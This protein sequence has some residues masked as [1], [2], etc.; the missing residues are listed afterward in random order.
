MPAPVFTTRGQRRLSPQGGGGPG[1]G[2]DAQRSWGT[3]YGCGRWSW[4]RS[5]PWRYPPGSGR[6]SSHGG[7]TSSLVWAAAGVPVVGRRASSFVSWAAWELSRR[8]GTCGKLGSSAPVPPAA[9]V[10]CRWLAVTPVQSFSSPRSPARGLAPRSGLRLGTPLPLRLLGIVVSSGFTRFH[11]RASNPQSPRQ[12]FPRFGEVGVGTRGLMVDSRSAPDW[13]RCLW[14]CI[15]L[16][17]D[18]LT[19][20]RGEK[21]YLGCVALECQTKEQTCEALVGSRPVYSSGYLVV[22]RIIEVCWRIHH[23][24]KLIPLYCCNGYRVQEELSKS[25]KIRPNQY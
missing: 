25:R 17:E 20:C 11:L 14:L 1:R 6:R 9:P 10:A 3:R 19:V 22:S 23:S 15:S 12:R 13:R 8:F 21:I 4:R 16:W 24:T 2:R 5:P 18:C 7:A